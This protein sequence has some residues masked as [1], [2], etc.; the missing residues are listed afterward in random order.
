MYYDLLA[1]FSTVVETLSDRL[2]RRTVVVPMV[3]LFILTLPL[4]G[5]DLGWVNGIGIMA[6]FLLFT[7]WLAR[8]YIRRTNG[9]GA[10]AN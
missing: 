3:V 4:L 6:L 2:L 1:R 5:G 7:L 8:H 10:G 9:P